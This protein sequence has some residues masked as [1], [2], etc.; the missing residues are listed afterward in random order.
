MRTLIFYI[1]LFDAILFTGVFWYLE[2]P[3][4]IILLLFLVFLIFTALASSQIRW[5]LFVSSIHSGNKVG[6]QI[7]LTF[8]DGPHPVYTPLVLDIL[9]QHQAKASFFLIGKNAEKYPYLVERIFEE[10]HTI[11]NHSYSHSNTIGF[12]S[13]NQWIQEIQS[14]NL[15]IQKIIGKT[16]KLFRPPFGIT[17]PHLGLALKQTKMTSIGWNHRTFD[18]AQK[19]VD[20]IVR[21]LEQNVQAGSIIL[22]HDSHERIQPLLEQLLTKLANKNLSF[23]SLNELLDEKSYLEV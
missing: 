4:Y 23:V 14:T 22:L 9:K 3:W 17:T 11:G 2:F 8:D 10:G 1:L 16:P 13:K 12:S 19:N 15:V 20:A 21:K 7:A 18:T 6:N 5:N